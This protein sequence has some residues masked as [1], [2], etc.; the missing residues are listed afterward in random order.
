[1]AE[2]PQPIVVQ[3]DVFN[4]VPQIAEGL[5]V[6]HADVIV[7]QVNGPDAGQRGKLVGQQ[8]GQL[9]VAQVERVEPVS[10]E[11]CLLVELADVVVGEVDLG[12]D[13]QLVE[14]VLV[15]TL[16]AAVDHGDLLEVPQADRGEG[17]LGQLPDVVA[18]QDDDLKN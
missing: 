14:G 16:D 7:G 13:L 11:E 6:N 10:V 18:V 1:M 15:H 5:L 4:T 2:R 8:G 3:V 12:E 17:V 9:V